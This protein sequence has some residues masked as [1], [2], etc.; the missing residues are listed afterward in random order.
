MQTSK[1]M[2]TANRRR[3]NTMRFLPRRRSRHSERA[4][5]ATVSAAATM[6][7]TRVP[8]ASWVPKVSRQSAMSPRRF[9]GGLSAYA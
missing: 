3:V 2:A 5:M 6:S 7:K 4:E 9:T 8:R 1:Q